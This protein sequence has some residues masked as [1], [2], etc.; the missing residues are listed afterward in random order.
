MVRARVP[1][2]AAPAQDVY[3]EDAP[4]QASGTVVNAAD[5]P[6]GG[7]EL[8]AVVQISSLDS[9]SVLRLGA[10]EGPRLELLPLPSA[11]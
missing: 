4:G 8:L 11:A 2:H 7:S 1:A 10:P 3:A 9:A 5:A 6:Q